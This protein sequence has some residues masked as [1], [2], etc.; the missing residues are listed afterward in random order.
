MLISRYYITLAHT[1][2]NTILMPTA[3][4]NIDSLIVDEMRGH[5]VKES[6]MGQ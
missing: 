5:F 6:N 1:V 3:V 2:L 4:F